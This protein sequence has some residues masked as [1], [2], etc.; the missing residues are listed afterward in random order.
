MSCWGSQAHPNL[1]AAGL[2]YCKR[3]LFVSEKEIIY[4]WLAVTFIAAA[5]ARI[6]SNKFCEKTTYKGRDYFSCDGSS[7]VV[8]IIYHVLNSIAVFLALGLIA[9]GTYLTN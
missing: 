8:K 6:F 5:A 3:E 9:Y 1:R 4:W 2:V 7:V